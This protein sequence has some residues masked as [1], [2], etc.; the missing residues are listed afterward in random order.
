ME[1][2][3]RQ[4]L[5]EI[6]DTLSATFPQT[7][8]P[9]RTFQGHLNQ[10]KDFRRLFY[11]LSLFLCHPL[12]KKHIQSSDVKGLS[13]AL[14]D[15]MGI[16]KPVM[17]DAKLTLK[18]ERENEMA[19]AEEDKKIEAE[20]KQNARRSLTREVLG[21]PS[22][23][24]NNEQQKP[25]RARNDV[26]LVPQDDL[27]K[28]VIRWAAVLFELGTY[29]PRV[30][31]AKLA[32]EI[33][34]RLEVIYFSCMCTKI[35][36]N[37]VTTLEFLIQAQ[38]DA[39]KAT[40]TGDHN[41]ATAAV[42]ARIA[43]EMFSSDSQ[44]KRAF[45]TLE[46]W[47]VEEIMKEIGAKGPGGPGQ[48]QQAAAD[49]M[50]K[51]QSLFQ[52]LQTAE[53]MPDDESKL[54][55]LQAAGAQIP[56]ELMRQVAKGRGQRKRGPQSQQDP[57]PANK[58][59]EKKL[60]VTDEAY[61]KVCHEIEV[62]VLPMLQQEQ[63]DIL[64]KFIEMHAYLVATGRFDSKPKFTEVIPSGAKGLTPPLNQVQGLV[65]QVADPPAPIEEATEAKVKAPEVK[66]SAPDTEQKEAIQAQS[67][68]APVPVPE[69][70]PGQIV[71]DTPLSAGLEQ[72]R[73]FGAQGKTF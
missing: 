66:V 14:T 58:E 13:D 17:N 72:K 60:L 28:W 23:A 71:F 22:K 67:T 48:G 25:R 30:D 43:K 7:C 21:R 20:K 32:R 31:K 64:T 47:Q 56:D 37:N 38:S 4:T 69:K 44:L 70:T 8:E 65:G 15:K 50:A 52:A 9:F 18:C 36:G 73:V 57:R 24:K 33:L 16:L 39:L 68:K 35:L 54:R 19:A 40:G 10:E 55:L 41:A 2:T 63:K 46:T 29:L 26:F 49:E 53:A 34:P 51:M 45:K 6:L 1:T 42:A 5:N 61:S 62:K 11:V 59:Q 3:M 12:I 27:K